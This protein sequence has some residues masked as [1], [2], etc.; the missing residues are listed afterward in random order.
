VAENSLVRIAWT[1]PTAAHRRRKD[2]HRR[3]NL[4][5]A[6]RQLDRAELYLV[7]LCSLD[8]AEEGIEAAVDDLI[9]D[10]RG[11]REHLMRAKLSA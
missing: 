9:R 6:I 11:L 5:I 4:R 8:I 7:A 1:G 10:V 3:R 2:Q